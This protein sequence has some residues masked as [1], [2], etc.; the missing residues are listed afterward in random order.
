[1]KYVPAAF[2]SEAIAQTAHVVTDGSPFCSTDDANILDGKDSEEQI[3]V[4]SIAPVLVHL[5]L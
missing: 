5:E 2:V 1:M 4:G 3:F